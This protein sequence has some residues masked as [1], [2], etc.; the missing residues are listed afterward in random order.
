MKI[1]LDTNVYDYIAKN[2]FYK[3]LKDFFQENL[4][5]IIVSLGI[6]FEIARISDEELRNKCFQVVWKLGTIYPKFPESYL[7]T[8]EVINEFKRCRPDWIYS[9]PHNEKEIWG[10][11]HNYRSIINFFKRNGFLETN[12]SFD[13][14]ISLTERAISKGNPM[15]KSVR[16]AL[17]K[18]ENLEVGSEDPEIQNLFTPLPDSERFWRSKSSTIWRLA[19]KGD[20]SMRDYK[21]WLLPHL[22]KTS[23]GKMEWESFWLRDLNS[24][25]VPRTYVRGLTEYFQLK[26]RITHGNMID[27]NHSLNLVGNHLFL[28]GD[29][30]YF[31]VLQKVVRNSTLRIAK[32]LFVDRNNNDACD[33]IMKVVRTA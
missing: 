18:Y 32:P 28:T 20:P 25:N 27:S 16:Q 8:Q 22:R 10:Y 17:L 24:R 19:L 26:F 21:D 14:Y 31:E 11:V 13:E 2:G 1:F 30:N 33:E 23:V 7:E 5:D 12:E 29:K 4:C 6:V 3:K 15:D 9:M